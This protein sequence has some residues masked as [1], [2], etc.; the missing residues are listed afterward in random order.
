MTENRI[1]FENTEGGSMM[2]YL[3]KVF[4]FFTMVSLVFVL[5]A[6][7]KSNAGVDILLVAKSMGLGMLLALILGVKSLF[8]DI[9]R[10][11]FTN[12]GI[13]LYSQTYLRFKIGRNRI[14]PYRRCGVREWKYWKI[15]TFYSLQ[16]RDNGKHVCNILEA[17]WKEKYSAI[18]KEIASRIEASQY[19]Y[20]K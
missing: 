10:I 19:S 17:N 9:T 15:T 13:F 12:E 20:E 14:I 3:W 8:T 1:I 4:S 11:E 5:L 18:K 16:V 2:K 7:I 6:M